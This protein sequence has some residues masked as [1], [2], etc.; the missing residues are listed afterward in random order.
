MMSGGCPGQ[1]VRMMTW[2]SEMSGSASRGIFR[3]DQMPARVSMETIANTR[4]RFREHS[5]MIREI[6]S[7][8]A[9]SIDAEFLHCRE[10]A[11]LLHRDGYLPRS[12]HGQFLGALVKSAGFVCEFRSRI[13]CGHSHLRH[14]RHEECYCDIGSWYYCS[15]AAGEIDSK[16]VRSLARRIGIG[17][18]LDL[19]RLAR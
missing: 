2:T 12:S 5:S 18:E 13:H 16:P 1:L 8:A 11:V 9:L 15:I 6:I 4:K 19:D 14:G 7:H 10:L 17:C 3:R